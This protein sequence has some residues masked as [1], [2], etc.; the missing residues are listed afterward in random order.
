LSNCGFFE[1]ILPGPGDNLDRLQVKADDIG[2]RITPSVEAKLSERQKQIM[3]LLVQGENLTSR[4]CEQK[5][6]ISRD[7][8]NRDF[9]YLISLNLIEP[10]GKGR[11]RYYTLK[12]QA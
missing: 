1:V 6:G 8:A 7:T 9:K 3:T 12:G 4:R 11:G 2:Q 5:F 10:N